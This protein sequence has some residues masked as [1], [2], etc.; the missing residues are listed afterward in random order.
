MLIAY[1]KIRLLRARCSSR[2]CPTTRT[3]PHELER[4]FPPP[5]PDRYAERM[6]APPAAPRDHRDASSP[7]SSSTAPGTTFAFRLG[8]ETGAPPAML[9]RAYA[10]AREVFAMRAFWA[11]VEAL[12]NLADADAQLD[13]AGRG[14]QAGRARD[15]LA[16]ARQ[17]AT[18]RHRGDD[19]AFGRRARRR[20]PTR[21]RTCS[22]APTRGLPARAPRSSDRRGVPAELAT[23]GRRDAVVL[24]VFDVVEVRRCDGPRP[25]T[26]DGDLLRGSARGSSSTGCATASSSCRGPTAGRRSRGRR[27]ATTS[28]TSTGCSPRRSWSPRVPARTPTPRSTPGSSA[29]ARRRALPGDALGYQRLARI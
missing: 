25:G 12:D 8:E 21:C 18:D 19:R 1:C 24:A 17:P 2:T 10:A 13:D 3:S 14:P 28:T 5:L 29:T 11:A 27:C 7:T 4:Y 20:S 6:R 16:G 26:V 15:S 23:A 22:R 9:A